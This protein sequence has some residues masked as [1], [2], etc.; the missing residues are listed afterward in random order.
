MR[1][2]DQQE[3][4]SAFCG[5]HRRL[6]FSPYVQERLSVHSCIEVRRA[7]A[8]RCRR[9]M[10]LI[11]CID[12]TLKFLLTIVVTTNIIETDGREAARRD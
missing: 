5:T 1:A 10:D 9:E 2:A 4:G 7:S 11:G 8:V 3:E 12:Q 6:E